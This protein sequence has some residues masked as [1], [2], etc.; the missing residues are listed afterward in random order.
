FLFSDNSPAVEPTNHPDLSGDAEIL[1]LMSAAPE[2]YE[3]SKRILAS[4]EQITPHL[5]RT[6]DVHSKEFNELERS[7]TLLLLALFKGDN[8][9]GDQ[10][11]EIKIK[12]KARLIRLD[13]QDL[14]GCIYMPPFAK[15]Y[16]LEY[17]ETP[18]QE[19]I[20]TVAAFIQTI[21]DTTLVCR[22]KQPHSK[23][24]EFMFKTIFDNSTAQ[25]VYQY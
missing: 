6:L 1:Q 18:L 14:L 21:D 8:T 9:Y 23:L 13:F 11:Q 10:H 22:F 4:L 7:K 15:E 20:K 3:A 2:L 16:Q 19:E 12:L 17:G 24:E 25:V 5:K